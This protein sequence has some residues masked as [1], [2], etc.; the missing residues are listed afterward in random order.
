MDFKKCICPNDFLLSI[1]KDVLHTF[2]QKKAH[3]Y[4]FMRGQ[5]KLIWVSF[6]GLQNYFL[7]AI[8]GMIMEV[9]DVEVEPAFS[10]AI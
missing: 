4:T 6:I 1:L 10:F 5:N 9:C 2:A 8:A 3:P 7:F